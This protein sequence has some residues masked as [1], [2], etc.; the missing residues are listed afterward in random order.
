LIF[1][2]KK[3][4]IN[5]ETKGDF[6]IIQM[7]KN[8]TEASDKPATVIYVVDFKKK[9]IVGETLINNQANDIVAAWGKKVPMKKKAA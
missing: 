1:I 7:P 5:K 8:K 4:K 6:M 9:K 2:K 3:V